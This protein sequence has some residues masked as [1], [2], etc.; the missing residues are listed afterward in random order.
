[1]LFGHLFDLFIEALS[2]EQPHD[3]TAFS[4]NMSP[5]FREHIFAEHEWL[6]FLSLSGCRS[7]VSQHYCW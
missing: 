2:L 3:E 1:M 6:Q 7:E 5:F 4:R